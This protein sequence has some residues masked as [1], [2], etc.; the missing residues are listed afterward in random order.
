[1]AVIGWQSVLAL[2]IAAIA[3]GFGYFRP[4]HQD[5]RHAVPIG[6]E[7]YPDEEQQKQESLDNLVKDNTDADVVIEV[8][9]DDNDDNNSHNPK[10]EDVIFVIGDLHGDAKCARQWIEAI[11]VVDDVETPKEWLQP[12]A[13]VVF[14]G[15]Y[16]DKGPWSYQ[17]MK[18]VRTLTDAFPDRVTALMGNHEMELLKDRDPRRLSKYIHYPYSSVHPGEYLNFLDRDVDDKDELVL[19]LLLNASLEV[20]AGGYYRSVVYTP[21]VK[22]KGTY[23]VTALMP[24]SVQP[25]VRDRLEEYQHAYLKAFMSNTTLG[26]WVEARPVAHVQNGFFFV[27]GGISKAAADALPT[28]QSVDDLNKKVLTNAQDTNFL[29]FIEQT[30]EGRIASDLML[31]RGNHKG[32]NACFELA[33][34]LDSMEGVERLVVGHTPGKNVRIKCDDSF[35]AVDSLLGRYIRTSGNHYCPDE[36]RAS[37]TGKFVCPPLTEHCE[38]QIIVITGDDKIELLQMNPID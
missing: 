17:T 5:Q 3:V 33:A 11:Q 29:W 7:P 24:E 9:T 31:H 35:F 1:M 10:E 14:M 19:D 8:E 16:I 13:S 18:L 34:M 6:E 37:R 30:R 2:L 28:L 21:E 26:K 36:G 15:D 12:K 38:G 32:E 25:L 22:R 23:A 20:Y 4:F 27:H